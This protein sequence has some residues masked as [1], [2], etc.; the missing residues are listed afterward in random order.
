MDEI[1]SS[2]DLSLWQQWSRRPEVL[3]VMV[4]TAKAKHVACLG[5]AHKIVCRKLVF[6]NSREGLQIQACR[7]QAECTQVLIGMESTGVYWKG[8]WAQLEKLGFALVCVDPRAMHHNRKTLGGNSSKTDASDA[9]CGLD[10]LEQGK[11]LL[12][13]RRE[14]ELESAY[15]MMKHYE[16]SRN[17][18]VGIRNQLR[19]LLHL[20]F[21]ELNARI[22]KLDGK[23]ALEFLA[24]N[25]TP[26]SIRQLGPK[27]F[28]Q[29]WRGPRGR[30]GR[31]H[32]EQLYEL[33]KSSI[34]LP[35]ETGALLVEIRTLVQEL[36]WQLQT[37]QSW[38]EKARGFVEGRPEFALVQG[39][40]GI[41]EKCAVGL[42]SAV[43][44]PEDFSHAKQWVK[45]A[46]LDL[47]LFESGESLRRVPKISRQGNAYLRSWLYLAA[48]NAVQKPGPFQ[49][50]YERRQAASP[51][52]GAK[53]RA[54]V[55]VADKL[56][57]VLFAMLRDQKAYDP[58]QDA[59]TALAYAQKGN[60]QKRAA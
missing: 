2:R 4:D 6:H 54:L 31:K 5:T 37:Q 32:F 46:G 49:Q 16:D 11:F 23:T 28:L 38:F 53:K 20:A 18:A 3:K 22:K 41:G 21:P 40:H 19:A 51:G 39:I 42:I 17:R 26:A 55:A 58:S 7:A 45:L 44:R 48:L 36:R 29:R 43:G 30:W 24:R 52:K 13:V 57:R 56:V 12:P 34:G 25:P 27:R 15:R 59:R 8:L 9:Q 50:L 47:R 35:D 1:L 60:V 10:L 33:A 14:P